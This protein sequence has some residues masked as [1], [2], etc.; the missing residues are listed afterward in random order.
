VICEFETSMKRKAT[1]LGSEVVSKKVAR[2]NPLEFFDPHFHIWDVSKHHDI[3]ILGGP[4][5][6]YPQFT[7]DHMEKEFKDVKEV[8]LVG[9]TWLECICTPDKVVK[10]AEWARENL[11]DTVVLAPRVD[12]SQSKEYC[13]ET[14]EA[15]V[16]RQGQ[17]VVGIRHILN[18]EPTWPLTPENHILSDIWKEN[19]K[20]LEE[21]NLSFD[22]QANPHQLKDCAEFFKLNQKVPV[23]VNHFGTLK[24][25][26][27]EAEVE[28]W[29]EGMKLLNELPHVYMKIS[30]LPYL[31]ENWD[32]E[33]SPVKGL[34]KEVIDIFGVQRCMFASNYP[35]DL[36][37]FDTQRLVDGFL[38]LCDDFSHEDKEWLFSKTAKEAYRLNN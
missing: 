21:F 3:N 34:V 38:Y 18:F 15:M 4:A 24:S 11:P 26:T 20:L 7:W 35:V 23:I 22:C 27:D 5:E 32:K 2:P 36:L 6:K 25:A 8:V 13:K 9:G 31:D 14:L 1:K 29:R 33:E 19:F 28:Q 12:L 37:T 30:M 16:K 10:E 17:K